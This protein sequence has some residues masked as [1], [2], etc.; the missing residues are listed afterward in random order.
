MARNG[1][2]ARSGTR[3]PSESGTRVP[4]LPVNENIFACF[5]DF[6]RETQFVFVWGPLELH[7]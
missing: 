6:A 1:R 4:E 3:V 7:I 2:S 5:V